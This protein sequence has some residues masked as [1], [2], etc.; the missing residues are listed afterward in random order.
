MDPRI[1]A[2]FVS[3]EVAL[4]S[5]TVLLA[6]GLFSLM[7]EVSQTARSM[8]GLTI[9]GFGLIFLIAI[10]S[11]TAEIKFLIGRPGSL[12]R[13]WDRAVRVL[14]ANLAKYDDLQPK[15]QKKVDRLADDLEALAQW[16][17]A[18]RALNGLSE[19]F[20][21]ASARIA[22]NEDPPRARR[23]PAP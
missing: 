8:L 14:E 20:R 15:A 1:L 9:L 6:L 3:R 7:G 13:K 22:R 11:M 19:Q 23:I 16:M 2:L 4:S 12:D 10:F 5:G 17:E 18:F 21:A